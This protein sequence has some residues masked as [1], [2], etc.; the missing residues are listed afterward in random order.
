MKVREIGGFHVGGRR[1]TISGRPIEERQINFGGPVR[2]VDLNGDYITGQAY[3]QFTCL[4]A[5]SSPWP[6]VF[7]HGGAMTGVTWETTPD[8]RP[9]WQMLFLQAGFDAY[10]AD[11]VERGR[12]GWSPFPEIYADAPVFRTLDEAWEM[13]RIGPIGGYPKRVTFPETRFPAELYDHFAAQFVPRWTSNGAATVDAYLALLQKIGP[14]IIVAHSQGGNLACDLATRRPDLIKAV[15]AVEPAGAGDYDGAAIARAAACP[16]L[17]LW[18]DYIGEHPTWGVYRAKADA[19]AHALRGA[20]GV[21][22]IID[23]PAEGVAG[24]SHMPMSDDNSG[25]IAERVIMWLTE[26]NRL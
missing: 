24:N 23:L 15:V 25:E 13:F 9:G 20:G 26:R 22:D 11:A 6:I 8:G 17:V 2:K 10:V 14:A 18:G 7:I 4:E 19:H 5:P 1:A 12:A 21:A 3:V 16:H